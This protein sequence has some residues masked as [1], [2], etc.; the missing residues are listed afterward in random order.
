MEDGDSQQS[1]LVQENPQ[2]PNLGN[3]GGGGKQRIQ[4]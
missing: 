4:T 1:L 3:S 2:V